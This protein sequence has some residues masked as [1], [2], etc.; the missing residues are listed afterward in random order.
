MRLLKYVLAPWA[1]LLVYS[2]LSFFFGQNGLYARRHLEAEYMRLL[3]NRLALEAVNRRLSNYKDSLLNNNDALSVHARQLGFGHP[4]EE[5]IRVVG[6]GVATSVELPSGQA[7]YGTEH[8][9]VPNSTIMM[10]S[11][12]FGAGVLALFLVC[13]LFSPRQVAGGRRKE[14]WKTDYDQR[15]AEK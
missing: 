13:D 9:F 15:A 7:L 1:A 14:R 6:L 11:L 3:E 2:I 12:V 10:I 5:F 4:G 8:P